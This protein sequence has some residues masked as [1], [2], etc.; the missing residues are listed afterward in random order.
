MNDK[1]LEGISKGTPI[2]DKDYK[3]ITAKEIVKQGGKCSLISCTIKGFDCVCKNK[4][5][6]DLSCQ[7]QWAESLKNARQWLEENPEP[8]PVM[9][10]NMSMNEVTITPEMKEDAKKCLGKDCHNCEMYPINKGC[11]IS[12]CVE[13]IAS[14]PGV[15]DSAPEI[16]DN[17]QLWFYKGRE[18]IGK[19]IPY[20]RTLPKSLEDEIAE[21]Y[22][23]EIDTEPLLVKLVK[24]KLVEMLKEY[25]E[26]QGGK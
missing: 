12:I 1:T 2:N 8:K 25:N 11:A 16:A 4:H 18:Q 20:T 13:A 26:R 22:A 3:R 14:L 15:F 9:L 10:D 6:D 5:S 23:K 7:E 24:N 17:V 21:K 19:M